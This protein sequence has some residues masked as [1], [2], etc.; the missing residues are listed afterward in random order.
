MTTPH[1]SPSVPLPL[2]QY[3]QAFDD[4]LRTHIQRQRFREYLAGLLLPRDRDKT[5]TALMGAEPITQAQTAHVGYQYLGTIGKIANGIVAVTSLWADQQ[6]YC[7]LHVRPY[8]PAAHLAGGKQDPAFRTKPQLAL[9]TD[10]DHVHVVVSAPPRFSPAELAN[11]LK[12]YSSRYLRERFLHL[13][14]ICG[15]DHLRT[16]SSLSLKRDGFSRTLYNKWFICTMPPV[17]LCVTPHLI[18]SE[19]GRRDRLYLLPAY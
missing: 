3:A 11:L 5:L 1:D 8:T 18:S 14:R 13:K 12:G 19:G 17:E 15:K 10:Q 6:V 4:L 2:D 9:E 7:P 16:L